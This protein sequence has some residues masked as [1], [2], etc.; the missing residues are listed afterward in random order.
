MLPPEDIN[1]QN[2]GLR[3]GESHH[4]ALMSEE[5]MNRAKE[6][7]NLIIIPPM[8]PNIPGRAMISNYNGTKNA[9]I[10]FRSI[11]VQPMSKDDIRDILNKL[12]LV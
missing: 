8:K 6:I 2:I 12:A 9:N 5:E 1:I 4:E 10:P 11:D 3:P 7:G